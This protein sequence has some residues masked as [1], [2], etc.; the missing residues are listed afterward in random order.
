M[1]NA[2]SSPASIP[3]YLYLI[4][5]HPIYVFLQKVSIFLTLDKHASP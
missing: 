1:K 4:V 5:R 3:K 2:I